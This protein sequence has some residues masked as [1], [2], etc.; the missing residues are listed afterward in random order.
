MGWKTS[1]PHGKEDAKP[2]GRHVDIY[3][4]DDRG[5]RDN[6]QPKGKIDY[7]ENK[8]QVRGK[9]VKA[10]TRGASFS[11]ALVARRN[12]G[13]FSLLFWHHRLHERNVDF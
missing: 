4:T 5:K 3:P 12:L 13:A 1:T 8:T 11:L 6:D 2:I 7:D 10:R 9:L